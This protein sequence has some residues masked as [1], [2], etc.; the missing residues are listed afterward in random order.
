MKTL[1]QKAPGWSSENLFTQKDA[2]N[3]LRFHNSL[4]GYQMTPLH[5]LREAAAKHRVKSVLVKDESA[6]FGL[7]AFKGTGGSYAVFR[8]LC[9]RFGMDHRTATFDDFRNERIQKLCRN[10]T[11]VTATDGNH[12]KGV[13][14]ASRLFGCRSHVFMPAGSVEVRRQAIEN[15]GASTVQIL[16]LNYDRTVAHANRLAGENGWIL[17][18]DTAWEGY[19]EIPRWIVEGYLTL[20]S[21]VCEQADGCI[22]THV[23]LQAG[24]GAMAGGVAG[25]LLNRY[26]DC[27]PTITV[28]E[29]ETVACVYLS[30]ETGDGKPH[31]ID[32][33]PVTIMA[34][35]NCGTPCSITWPVLR[36]G[37]SF[38]CAC[39]DDITRQGMHAYAHPSGSDPVIVSGE[40]GAVTY[41]LLLHILEREELRTLWGIDT[42]S[43]IL[44]I[45]T[46][47]DTDPDAYVRIIN[48]F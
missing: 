5:S 33:D 18:Q 34:G 3:V 26:R 39:P 47:G 12:G 48:S 40:S 7:N 1:Q 19:E 16:P 27:P 4:P 46:E 6:R 8:I 11:F 35:L 14:W 28:V 23:F 13:A 2:D 22:P 30:A 42:S 25:Y 41:G 9:D 44:L 15:A 20:P 29:P 17:I 31:S 36:D 38:F 43:V 21:E 24:V 37:A 10:I 45:N 32:G